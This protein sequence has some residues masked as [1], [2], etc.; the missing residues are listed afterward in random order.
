[1]AKNTRT[2]S[3]LCRVYG[4]WACVKSYR[5]SIM[6]SKQLYVQLAAVKVSIIFKVKNRFGRINSYVYCSFKV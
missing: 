1:M 5:L 4:E 2:V 3:K 6:A